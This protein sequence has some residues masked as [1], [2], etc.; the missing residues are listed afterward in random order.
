MLFVGEANVLLEDCEGIAGLLPDAAGGAS[1]PLAAFDRIAGVS[2]PDGVGAAADENA[3]AVW[4]NRRRLD[5]FVLDGA[6]C[7]A[8][9]GAPA[10]FA[11]LELAS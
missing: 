4:W 10:P 8:A 5:K 2:L 3:V 7:E 11:L 1:L 6:A 9:A